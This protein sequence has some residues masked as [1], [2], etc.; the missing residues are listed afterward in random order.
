MLP[1][2]LAFAGSS[3][4]QSGGS[5]ILNGQIALH[6]AISSLHT[7]VDG[8]GQDVGVQSVAA[9]NTLDVTTMNDTH[10]TNNQYTSSIDISSDLGAAV[11]NVGGSVGVQGQAV[12]NSASISTDPN[13]TKI[14]N[15]QECDAIDPTSMANVYANGIGGDFSLSN[16][17]IGNSLEA[18]SNAANMPITTTQ[19]NHSNVNAMTTANVSNVAGSVS[20]TSAAIGNNAQIVHYST[21]N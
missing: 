6:T 15:T 10:V 19:I 21:G 20:V 8:V 13:I 12:C 2:T 11:T 14:N 1:L 7:T 5:Q 3:S 4:D 18:D 17:A 9:G 16:S